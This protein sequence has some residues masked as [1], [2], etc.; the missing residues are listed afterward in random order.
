M[1]RY[2]INE[3]DMMTVRTPT[4]TQEAPVPEYQR[5]QAVLSPSQVGEQARMGMRIEEL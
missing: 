2:E 5:R 3:K 4:G 1:V